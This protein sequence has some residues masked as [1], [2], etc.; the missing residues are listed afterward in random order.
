M[1]KSVIKVSTSWILKAAV[2]DPGGDETVDENGD[3][4][5]GMSADKQRQKRTR[6]IKNNLNWL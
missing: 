6:N 3:T 4:V 1:M 5:R 2:A